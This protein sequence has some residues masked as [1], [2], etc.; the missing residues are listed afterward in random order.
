MAHR[1]KVQEIFDDD[2]EEMLSV[3]N[4][5]PHSRTP[6]QIL[7]LIY[8]DG[9]DLYEDEEEEEEDRK[10]G[11]CPFMDWLPY[12]V[13]LK[14]FN[15]T[16]TIDLIQF[17]KTSKLSFFYTR[18]LV[19]HR[20]KMPMYHPINLTQDQARVLQA[21]QNGDNLFC[22]GTA[23]TGKS[24]LI[25]AISSLLD[26]QED[27]LFRCAPTGTAS[28]LIKGVTLHS[29]FAPTFINKE[30]NDV[31]FDIRI[32]SMS[33][34]NY[35]LVKVLIIDEI[36]MIGGFEF[37]L[38][39]RHL[40]RVKRQP[41]LP[42]GGVQVILFGDFCQIKPVD[43]K[44]SYCFKTPLWE[45]VFSPN[46]YKLTQ[47]VRQKAIAD[48]DV[49]NDVRSGSLS[50]TTIRALN[51][52]KQRPEFPNAPYLFTRTR[53]VEDFTRKKMSEI[54]GTA[55]FY[56]ARD[57][58]IS[59][60]NIV[61]DEL[62]LKTGVRVMLRKNFDTKRGMCNGTIGTVIRFETSQD[63]QEQIEH[64]EKREQMEY[65][66][67][68]D[69]VYKWLGRPNQVHDWYPIVKWDHDPLLYAL[70]F[71]SF[72]QR[73]KKKNEQN[74]IIETLVVACRFQLPIC[75]GFAMTIDKSQGA[76]L[77]QVNIDLSGIFGTGREFVALSRAVSLDC[78]SLRGFNPV[79]LRVD[80]DVVEFERETEWK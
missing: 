63:I 9:Q 16:H 47:V 36:S 60:P 26:D 52:M 7:K 38:L 51:L 45:L 64:N 46:S 59:P 72:E 4:P 77:Q 2:E 5:K 23:G 66:V 75:L 34:T 62:T 73:K 50:L 8:Q 70:G 67:E 78:V 19:R 22:T 6:E 20:M 65:P 11:Q 53:K 42:F 12:E 30:Q 49:L 27:T 14:I 54:L 15:L 61:P 29:T 21:V 71:Y 13:L 17:A 35:E 74:G 39:D 58:G 43:E 80:Q 32:Q 69:V 79:N 44:S 37:Q 24:H 25:H 41:S 3:P 18:D 10:G 40:R 48:I 56:K 33:C 68:H 55:Y 31:L 1:R 57:H 28:Y 76:T